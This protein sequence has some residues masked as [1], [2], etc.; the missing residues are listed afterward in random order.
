[1]LATGARATVERVVD[2]ADTDATGHYHHGT[3]TVELVVETLGATSLTYGFTVLTDGALCADGRLVVVN[4]GEWGERPEPWAERAR[5]VLASTG[6]GAGPA[7]LAGG[8]MVPKAAVVSIDR[9]PDAARHAGIRVQRRVEWYDTAASGS[10]HHSA[11]VRWAEAAECALLDRL[12]LRWVPIAPRVHYGADF[13]RPL[14]QHD[15]VDLDLHVAA[16]GRSSLTYT[17]GASR[18]GEAC[19]T[20]RMVVV[21]AGRQ[22]VAEPWPDS[23]RHA[24]TTAGC[25]DPEHL[26]LPTRLPHV[27]DP[28]RPP[29]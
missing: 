6:A 27:A 13:G 28:E 4:V 2:R 29:T 20:G 22:G 19:A 21:N 5:S 26:G 24:M 1:M 25:Q 16:V 3:V 7:A 12:G 9:H 11:L 23:V 17:F 10:Y 18:S 8:D 14:W 15:I